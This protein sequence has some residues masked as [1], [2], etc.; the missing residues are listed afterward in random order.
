MSS[1]VVATLQAISGAGYNGVPFTDVVDHV[2]PIPGGKEHKNEE[3]PHKI[4]RRVEGDRIVA[5]TSLRISA[6]CNRAPWWTGT[7]PA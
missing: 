3:E 7:R 6:H 5:D 2:V 4:L 1:L